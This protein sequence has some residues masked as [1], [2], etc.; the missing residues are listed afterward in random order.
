MFLVIS[1]AS[2][3]AADWQ[4]LWPEGAPWAKGSSEH[5]I[6]AILSFPAAPDNNPGCA[7]IVCPGGSYHGLAMDHEG[8][9]IVR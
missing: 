8:H 2:V 3:H 1:A 5:D 7:V 6:P 4:P 9:Q